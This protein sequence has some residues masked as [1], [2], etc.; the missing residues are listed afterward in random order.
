MRIACSGAEQQGGSMTRRRGVCFSAATGWGVLAGTSLAALAAWPQTTIAQSPTASEQGAAESDNPSDKDKPETIETI[1]VTTRYIREDIQTTPMAVTA[2]TSVQLEAANVTNISTLGAVVPN[3]WTV[4]GD[5]Q[6]AGTPRISM[7][8]VQQGASSS[9]AVP[10]AVAIYTDDVYHATTAG[11][12]LDLHDID[13]IEVNRGPQSTLSGNASIGGSIKIYTRDPVGDGSGFISYGRGSRDKQE[14]SA[15]IDLALSDT[16]AMRVSGHYERQDGFVDRL[17]FTC[18]MNRLG[19]P[20]LAG[21]LP[22][23]KPNSANQNCVL[24]TLGG[25]T[26]S[27]GQVKFRWRPTD[28]LDVLLT[29][30]N[31]NEDL[32]ETPETALMYQPNPNPNPNATV[33]NY[34]IAVRNAFG[35]QLD[36]RFLAPP[37]TDGY[38]TYATNCRPSLNLTTS[39]NFIAPSGFCYP[40]GKSAEHTLVSGKV[41]YEL[42]DNLRMTAIGA[43]TEYS[44]NFTQNG[45]QSPLGYVVSNFEN[46]G[47]Q[48][49]GELR[50]DGSL[51]GDRLEWIV[52]GYFLRFTGHQN[53]FIGVLLNGQTSTDTGKIE[54]QSGFFHLDYKITDEWRVSGGARYSDGSIAYR[55]IHPPVLTIADPITSAQTRT[56]WLLSTDY[57]I[58]DDVLAYA[59][60]A[61][62]SRPPGITTIVNT[63]RQLA[64]TPAE[65]LISYEI[66]VKAE[67]FNHRLRT[68][69]AGF[70]TDY[71]SLATQV[72]GFECL[73][74]PSPA[75]FFNATTDC[76]QFAPNT[77]SLQWTINAGIP[78]TITGVEL[79]VSALP[80]DGLHINWAGGYN[81]FESGIKTPG[82][83]GYNW[84]GNHR[85]P[86]V[87]M[88]ADVSYDIET[89]IGTFTPRVDWNWQSQQDFDPSASIRPPLPIYIVDAYSLW[90]AQIGYQSN[91]DNWSATLAVTNLDDK[92]YYY[93]IFQGLLNAQTRVGTP[94]EVSL[95][96]RRNF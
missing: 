25:G 42:A 5:S 22:S 35:I 4:P 67:M 83:P 84:P 39:P 14:A 16:V 76:Q 1:V 91:D 32:E 38:A 58:T 34:N 9:L 23:A 13:R 62:G 82:Q 19:T 55:F 63:A 10:P 94:R 44:N 57:K 88:H 50:F 77:G 59:S 80:I 17:D 51:L 65:E 85:Q 24:G 28:K 30:R 31:R 21:S 20:Q 3:L 96:V 70:Y 64:P 69:L 53:N 40:Q 78:A 6:S 75:T 8:G 26:T 49:S 95:S 11:S 45:D 48:K 79:E 87:N 68:N 37:G 18:E 2:Q 15:G 54:S 36:S 43:Y 73:G 47:Y 52:G 92:F 93:Q 90:N 41:H 71:E 81:H 89:S 29:A 12:E 33:E 7:R 27:I 86:S 74:Q 61:T 60:A 56:D 66:G 72:R 46:I